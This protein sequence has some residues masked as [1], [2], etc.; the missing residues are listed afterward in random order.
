VLDG[1]QA[2][3]PAL[4][5]LLAASADGQDR[6][7]ARRLCHAALRDWPAIDDALNQLLRKPLPRRARTARFLLVVGLAE[8]R[9]RREPDHA[10]V[11]CAVEAVRAGGWA[12][13]AGLTN[14]VLRNYL[15]RS[16]A[17]ESRHRD[18]PV[19]AWGYP[20]W[21]IERVRAD[22]PERWQEILAEGN[23]PP[24]LVLRVNRRH[25]SRE[26]ARSALLAAGLDAEAPPLLADALILERHAQVSSLPGFVEGGLSVQDGAAQLAT[27]AL[28]L[29]DGMRVLD[30]CAA[31]GGKSAHLL[32][33][34]RV[35]LTALES[36]PARLER[37]ASNLDRLGLSARCRAADATR[38]EDWWD[39][40]PFDRILID[41][42]CS[43]TGVIRRHPDIRW[44]RK[45]DDIKAL[46][47]TQ[48]SLLDALW[49]LLVPGGILVY[50]TCSLL[51]EENERQATSFVE[52]HGQIEVI[53]QLGWPGRARGPGHQILPG[54]A[55]MDGF[56]YLSV[57]RLPG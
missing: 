32:E 14:A 54:E 45:P 55:G 19:F 56:Y 36:D 6:A 21:L 4:E 23:R 34:A 39:G 27:E 18:D 53:E 37:L 24:P 29:G 46:V 31:P 7:L 26:Q 12:P 1:G 57:R 25:W 49:P 43:A 17:I 9:Q 47:S 38:P 41:A 30:A 42:P 40:Q 20:E 22:W 2:L 51:R 10:V 3:E 11:H 44:L 13:L 52:R 5:P 50:A 28:E 33:R 15:R 48:R 8:L 35:D 16:D